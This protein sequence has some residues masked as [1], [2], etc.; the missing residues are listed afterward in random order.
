MASQTS[1]L[2]RSEKI[3][4]K[5]HSVVWWGGPPGRGA[6]W[7]RTPS[8]RCRNNDIGTL[9][10]ASRP[11]GAS[12]ADQG[13]RPTKQ[14]RLLEVSHRSTD[15]P[16][17]PPP[18]TGTYRFPTARPCFRFFTDGAPKYPAISQRL[19]TCRYPR[20]SGI[21]VRHSRAREPGGRRLGS[22]SSHSTLSA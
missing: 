7:A 6:L 15:K 14:V 5:N 4:S 21:A 1:H 19:R 22:A 10:G 18:A 12:A 16:P 8:S 9:Q 20:F 2:R 13:V 11:T 3:G 17:R